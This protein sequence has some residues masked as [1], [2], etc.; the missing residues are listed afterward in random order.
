MSLVT[1]YTP[2]YGPCKYKLFG[3]KVQL[4]NKGT[5]I[6]KIREPYFTGERGKEGPLRTSG[7]HSK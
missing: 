6:H 1:T 3:G 5:V 2:P 4:Q 7:K